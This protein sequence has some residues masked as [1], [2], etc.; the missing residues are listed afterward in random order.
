MTAAPC[1]DLSVTLN[2]MTRVCIVLHV[3]AYNNGEKI[4]KLFEKDFTQ[5]KERRV[6]YDLY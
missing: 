1:R 3:H 4:E 6:A 2:Q 5:K